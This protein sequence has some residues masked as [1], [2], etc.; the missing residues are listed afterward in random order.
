MTP[1][2]IFDK[3]K[4]K[5]GDS[6]IE[7]KTDKPVEPFITVSPDK[8]DEICFFLRD[9]EEFQFDSLSCLSGVD[10]ADDKLGVTYHLFSYQLRHKV[11]LK[12]FVTKDNADVKSVV[13]VWLTANWHEREAFDLIGINFIGHPDLRRILLP[14]DWVGH[15]LRKDYEVPEFY[16]G[17]KVPY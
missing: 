6:I 12:I 5:F 17:M 14:D 13:P 3:L 10:Y 7:F 2:E 16:N 8:I 9:Y 11:I 1:Q 15:P 4:S